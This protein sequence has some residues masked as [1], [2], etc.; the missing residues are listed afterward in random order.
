MENQTNIDVN[1]INKEDYNPGVE[2]LIKSGF[3]NTLIEV[4]YNISVEEFNKICSLITEVD[5][6]IARFVNYIT[7]SKASVIL[8]VDPIFDLNRIAEFRKQ[9]EW[10]FFM[11]ILNL[12]KG[13]YKKVLGLPDLC[14]VKPILWTKEGKV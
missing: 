12:N 14:I 1:D 10:S 9:N 5:K 8:T 7:I 6:E 13:Y 2:L 4:N 11:D 3:Y